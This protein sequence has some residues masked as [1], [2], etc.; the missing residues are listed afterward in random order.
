VG[1]ISLLNDRLYSFFVTPRHQRRGVGSALLRYA[2]RLAVAKGVKALL[3]PSSVTA[4]GFYGRRG[5]EVIKDRVLGVLSV[6]VRGLAVQKRYH[7]LPKITE[8]DS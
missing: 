6:S 7:K 1:T 8:E 5:Y 3:T 4:F 2:E